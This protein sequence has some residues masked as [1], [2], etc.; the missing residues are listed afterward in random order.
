MVTQVDSEPLSTHKMS[1]LT[2]TKCWYK[3]MPLSTGLRV[4]GGVC[5]A[6]CSVQT[7][8]DSSDDDS[9]HDVCSSQF[10]GFKDDFSDLET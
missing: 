6:D 3:D 7:A 4:R 10:S 5:H 8:Y 1:Y 9:L 2:T